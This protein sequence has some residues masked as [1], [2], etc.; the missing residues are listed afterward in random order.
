MKY[1][2]LI[3]Q[4]CNLACDYCYIG[5]RAARMPLEVAAKIV[6]FAYS[7][8]PTDE[9]IEIG[10]FGGE[11]LLEL[12]LIDEIATLAK[13]HSLYDAGRVTLT[14][15]SNGTTLTAPA[16][17]VLRR[18][19]ITLGI[20][21]DG[22]PEVH[23]RHRRLANGRGTGARVEAAIRLA[24]EELPAV[25]V[26]AVYGPDTLSDLPR[27]VDYLARLGVKYIYLSPNVSASWAQAD[28]DVLPAIYASVGERY[29]AY[30]L[31]GVPRLV[32][33][34]DSKI[35]VILRQ[36]Y[37]PLERCRMGR[38]EYAFSPAGDIYP[39]ERLVG[40]GGEGH[41]IGSISEGLQLERLLCHRAP[42][43]PMN[44]DCLGCG[45][46][47]YCMNWCGCSNYFASGYYNR[48]SPFWCASEKASIRASFEV[49]KALDSAGV[50]FYDHLAGSP[51]ATSFG[52]LRPSPRGMP[53]AESN[54]RSLQVQ[55]R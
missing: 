18:H 5:Q 13:G 46:R 44:K 25:M 52:P 7:H 17:D 4:R 32:S 3:T 1:T 22:P 16:L 54:S 51:A 48:V 6:A 21:C 35:A 8:T 36:G 55:G 28:I 49:L 20:S 14:A 15:I 43:E 11:P 12:S 9:R 45:L 10:F 19:G 40:N 42:G 41:R 50:P 26:N 53:R 31:E 24:L 47:D 39:C 38:G 27:T 37:H 34:I 23:D 33:L 30:Y 2:L 29:A